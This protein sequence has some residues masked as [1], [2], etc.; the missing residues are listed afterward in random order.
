V[1]WYVGLVSLG[2][3][4]RVE[5]RLVGV[6]GPPTIGQAMTTVTTPFARDEDGTEVLTFAFAPAS[7]T[8]SEGS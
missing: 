8:P 3:V 5:G 1:P 7:P 2:D 4:I 6:D